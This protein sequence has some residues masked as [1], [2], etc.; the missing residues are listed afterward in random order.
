MGC[1]S[2]M[3][4]VEYRSGSKICRSQIRQRS[5]QTKTQNSTNGTGT[6]ATMVSMVNM[7]WKPIFCDVSGESKIDNCRVVSASKSMCPSNWNE[8]QAPALDA[9]PRRAG[10]SKQQASYNGTIATRLSSHRKWRCGPSH[11]ATLNTSQNSGCEWQ[12]RQ[13]SGTSNK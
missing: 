13:Y 12:L 3:K 4:S 11:L 8:W 6:L 9:E 1:R 5:K 7:L 2:G 10:P